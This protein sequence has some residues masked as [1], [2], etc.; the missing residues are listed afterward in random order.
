MNLQILSNVTPKT[1]IIKGEKDAPKREPSKDV[2]TLTASERN[3]F[4]EAPQDREPDQFSRS[5]TIMT[6]PMSKAV[7]GLGQRT[8]LISHICGKKNR[9]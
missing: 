5:A 4:G 3:E 1:P 6:S 8:P 2:M 7:K 9:G